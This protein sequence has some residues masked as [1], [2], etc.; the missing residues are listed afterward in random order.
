MCLA[1]WFSEPA[2][3][4][5]EG[6]ETRERILNMRLVDLKLMDQGSFLCQLTAVHSS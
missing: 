5:F 6:S 2:K 1:L 4:A 3:K